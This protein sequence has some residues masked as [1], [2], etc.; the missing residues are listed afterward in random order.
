MYCW[1]SLLLHKLLAL[2]E[3]VIAFYHLANTCGACKI[4]IKGNFPWSSHLRD[5]DD[6]LGFWMLR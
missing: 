6:K 3:M 5:W 4:Q 2:L 1:A